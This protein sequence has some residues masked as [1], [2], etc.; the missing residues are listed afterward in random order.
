M[1]GN[2]KQVFYHFWSLDIY[3]LI[4][5]GLMVNHKIYG[6]YGDASYT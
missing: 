1:A 4:V 6:L 2:A 5:L 3:P